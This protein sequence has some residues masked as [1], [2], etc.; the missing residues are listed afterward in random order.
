M[1]DELASLPVTPP[2]PSVRRYGRLT[3]KTMLLRPHMQITRPTVRSAGSQRIARPHHP[4]IFE[5]PHTSSPI[6]RNISRHMHPRRAERS[7]RRPC[8]A[9]AELTL[10]CPL[11]SPPKYD[12]DRQSRQHVRLRWL[13][14]GHRRPTWRCNAISGTY[15]YGRQ[16]RWDVDE[17]HSQ[18]SRQYH[19]QSPRHLPSSPIA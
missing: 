6:S 8:G 3:V 12:L 13:G 16:G 15:W 1:A 4:S 5:P 7:S 17:L 11:E 18:H 19:G 9:T 10:L 14:T 2:R